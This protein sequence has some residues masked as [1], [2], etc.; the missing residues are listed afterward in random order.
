MCTGNRTEGSN[1]SLS[2][3]RRQAIRAFGSNPSL[4]ARMR[5]RVIR[6]VALLAGISLALVACRN[7][8][9][10]I[11]YTPRSEADT[12]RAEEPPTGGGG[13]DF[14]SSAADVA[15][16]CRAQRGKVGKSGQVSAC[17]TPHPE[18]GATLLTLVEYCQGAV[19][20]V[21]S[22]MVLEHRDAESW[23]I[24]F[25]QLR[26]QLQ[27]RYGAPDETHTE[28][29]ASCEEDFAGCVKSGKASATLRWRWED[30]HAV[31]LRIGSIAQVPAAISVSY[32]DREAPAE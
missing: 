4:S 14:G 23:L 21:H 29:P 3:K 31:M 9:R 26:R 17:T 10:P 16:K 8:N 32:S 15:A 1:P 11:G 6:R 5:R 12:A 25:E 18:V 28:F 20:R 2:A 22:L 13:F 19:C 30:G 27:V 24:P 7:N